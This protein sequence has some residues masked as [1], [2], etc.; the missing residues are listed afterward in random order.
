VDLALSRRFNVWAGTHLEVRGEVFNVLNTPPLNAPA[1]I[2]GAANFGSI[3]S[4]GDPRVAQLAAKL[5][6]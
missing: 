6:F 4:A 5:L 3:T 2:L 1:A